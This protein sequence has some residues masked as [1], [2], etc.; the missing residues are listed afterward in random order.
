C[1]SGPNDI[2]G[3]APSESPLTH[4]NNIVQINNTAEG[5]GTTAIVARDIEC[6]P[7]EQ[8]HLHIWV[9]DA[10]GVPLKEPNGDCNI[11][12]LSYSVEQI[13]D[14]Y[15]PGDSSTPPVNP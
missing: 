15:V 4:P 2:W 3:C 14:G 13:D 10:L 9:K 11:Y 7:G 1:W 12:T 8:W 5:G 6:Q